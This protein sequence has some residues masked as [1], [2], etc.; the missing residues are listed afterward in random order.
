VHRI[1]PTHERG[2][3]LINDYAR[4]SVLWKYDITV[5]LF[6]IKAGIIPLKNRK[7]F[8]RYEDFFL[9]VRYNVSPSKIRVTL[10]TIRF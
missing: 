5:F 1:A 10:S 6:F 4:S 8:E 9:K 2:E 7:I 3:N